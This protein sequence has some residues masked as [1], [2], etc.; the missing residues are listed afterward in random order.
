[1]PTSLQALKTALARNA[2]TG[3]EPR[4]NDLLGELVSATSSPLTPEVE[5][6]LLAI[7]RFEGELQLDETSEMPHS[8]PP[9]EMLKSLNV[10][11]L[12]DWTGTLFL[13]TMRRL[14]A[15]STSAAFASVVRAVIQ[16]IRRSSEQSHDLEEVAETSYERPSKPRKT[17]LFPYDTQSA[18]LGMTQED[19]DKGQLLIRPLRQERGLTFL[20]D[21][22]VRRKEKQLA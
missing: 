13:V 6:L 20:A 3:Q 19:P 2:P 18:V 14:E 10:Q 22:S 15:T 4:W 16:R 8:M 9:E 11:A 5:R 21:H 12:G 17:M 1:M 7:L